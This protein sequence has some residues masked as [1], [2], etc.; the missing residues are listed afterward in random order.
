MSARSTNRDSTGS[1]KFRGTAA[2]TFRS[3][4]IRNYRLYVAGQTAKSV[5]ACANL[6]RICE[7]HLAG[8]YSTEIIDLTEN[9]ILAAGDQIE[10]RQRVVR[11]GHIERAV[12]VD[13]RLQFLRTGGRSRDQ[14]DGA[15]VRKKLREA[16]ER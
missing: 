4:G 16:V 14:W 10:G 6:K 13:R 15:A 12:G 1:T 5:T 11:L 2:R 3:L 9:P 7:T 8:Q